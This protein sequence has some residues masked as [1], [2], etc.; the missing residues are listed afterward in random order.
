MIKD[1]KQIDLP[2]VKLGDLGLHNA[3]SFYVPKDPNEY[4]MA[5]FGK[6][7]SFSLF[8]DK[9]ENCPKGY[10]IRDQYDTPQERLLEYAQEL[11]SEHSDLTNEKMSETDYPYPGRK[12]NA[13]WYDEKLRR[14]LIR[15]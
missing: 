15:K 3:T 13:R 4:P 1:Y 14:G 7:N 10:K 2:K 6:G 11:E 5:R 9:P 8:T 12:R